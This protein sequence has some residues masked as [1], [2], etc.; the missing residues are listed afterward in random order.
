MLNKV[1]NTIEKYK[2]IE[3]NDKVLVAVQVDL[4]QYLCFIFYMN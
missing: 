1:K 2:L 3:E 4:I